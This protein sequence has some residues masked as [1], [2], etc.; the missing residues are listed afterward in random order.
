MRPSTNPLIPVTISRKLTRPFVRFF[1]V[2]AAGGIVLLICTLLALALANIPATAEAFHH[3]WHT[4]TAIGIGEFALNQPLEFWI[5]DGLMTIFFFVVGLEIKR[6]IVHGE[7]RDP[8]KAAL[9]V[10]GA[11]G[12]MLAPAGVYL[13]FESSGPGRNGWGIPMATDIAFVVG[14]LALLGKRVPSGLK[15]FLLSLAIADDIGA[16]LVIAIFYSTDLSLMLLGLGGAGFAL[17]LLMNRIGVRSVPLYVVVGATI[18]LC[19]LKSGVHPTI[20]GVIIGLITPTTA[21]IADDFLAVVVNRVNEDLTRPGELHDHHSG[22]LEALQFAAKEARSP[23][24][25]LETGLHPWVA[26]L[27]MPLFAL[28]NAGV[29]VQPAAVSG[30]VALAVACGLLLG[31]PLGITLFCWLAVKSRVARLPTNVTWPVMVGAGSLGGIGF[32]MSIFVAGLALKGEL[33][34]AAKIG[35]LAGSCA[36][37]IL[38]CSI[39]LMTMKSSGTTSDE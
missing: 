38:G 20:A 3:L 17:M 6:E 15:I 21:H 18:W 25:R 29:T 13:I 5:N 19:F 34:D 30:M 31:K 8:K 11:L 22:S 36:S 16:V 28:A 24:E 32:T 39:L 2:E 12:G 1:R 14:F 35:T 23:L 33:L 7:L 10:L 37:A 26:F 4:P 27:I 9:P